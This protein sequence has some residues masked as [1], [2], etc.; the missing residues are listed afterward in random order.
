VNSRVAEEQDMDCDGVVHVDNAVLT[1][2]SNAENTVAKCM[3]FA[4]TSSM[5]FLS[6][7]FAFE[8]PTAAVDGML[9][10]LNAHS[11]VRA[12][13]RVALTAARGR[14]LA[15]S[16]TT[17]RPSPA[18][19]YSAMDGYALRMADIASSTELWQSSDSLTLCVLGESCIGHQPSPM[20]AA[21]CA[22][23]IA[24]G[25]AIPSGADTV[26]KREDAGE[27]G[28][29]QSTTAINIT[30]T[31]A[32]KI[33]TGQNIRRAGENAHA[34]SIVVQEGTLLGAA[35]MGTLAAVGESSPLVATR[36]RVV[37]IT[38]GDELVD[39]DAVPD[40][41]EIRNSNAPTLHAVLGSH[42]WIDVVR[43]V[44]V[45]DDGGDLGAVLQDAINAADAVVLSGGV[46][47]GHRDQVRDA[48]TTAGAKIV[49]HGLPQR[50][51]KPM[52]GAVAT[53][54]D[55]ARIAIFGLP[56]NPISALVT[57]V[58]IVVPVLAACAG[59]RHWPDMPRIALAAIDDNT[60]D[61]W[62]HRLVRITA[63]G[64]AELVDGRGSGDIIA[65]GRSDGFIEIPPHAANVGD[66]STAPTRA[67]FRFYPWPT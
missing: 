63:D 54:V 3:I 55:G 31:T 52:L 61:L 53:R 43:I 26:L 64:T 17:D 56:G 9:L 2:S 47:M 46:S 57:C 23:R 27:I 19:D 66:A 67:C 12:T 21:P 29:V 37:I 16:I 32:A 36:L 1:N 49:F 44:H 62:W 34:G 58:R 13:E 24:T 51:G 8:S 50:P 42:A 5:G 39:C 33:R 22:M 30:R 14:F 25:A 45:R 7:S 35:A 28:Q 40:R 11:R 6:Q 15:T 4:G 41:F 18:F 20:N 60:L 48:V 59:A 38:T 65:G 10:E